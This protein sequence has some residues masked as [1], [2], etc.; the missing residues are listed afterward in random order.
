MAPKSKERTERTN[1]IL[2]ERSTAPCINDRAAFTQTDGPAELL[3]KLLDTD[4]KVLVFNHKKI[5]PD[6]N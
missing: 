6:I 4:I 1:K 2:L 5:A 3:V